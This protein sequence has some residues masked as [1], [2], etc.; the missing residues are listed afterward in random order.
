MLNYL[1]KEYAS[2]DAQV[3]PHKFVPKFHILCMSAHFSTP[4]SIIDSEPDYGVRHL[5]TH[6]GHQRK[7]PQETQMLLN[8]LITKTLKERF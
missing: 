7:H 5:N 4:S 1:V 6:L 8:I 3:T 2:F